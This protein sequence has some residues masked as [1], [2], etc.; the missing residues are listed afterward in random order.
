MADKEPDLVVLTAEVAAAYFDNNTIEPD[1]IGTVIAAIHAALKAIG[2]P[3]E[4]APV[5]EVPKPSA[6]QIRK[7]ITPDSL[8]SFVDGRPFKT[9]KRHL[10]LQGMTPAD[11]RERFGLPADY[12][13]V[14][15]NYSAA[16]SSLA[17]AAGLG[18]G[19]RKKPA[20]KASGR[21]GKA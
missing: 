1:K 10:A 12:P 17:I 8:I 14:A 6:A 3:A 18:Q 15:P 19:G 20:A 7:S 13:M 2:D 21:K 16:R 9:L 11:Y 4:E 5:E